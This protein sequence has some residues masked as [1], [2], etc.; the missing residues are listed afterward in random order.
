MRKTTLKLFAIFPL[1]LLISCN[2]SSA[3]NVKDK[4]E[5]LNASITADFDSMTKEDWDASINS[6][7]NY[8]KEFEEHK[9]EMSN[10]ERTVINRCIGKFE[11]LC[12]KRYADD[13]TD[14]L[15]DLGE[16]AESFV[17]EIFD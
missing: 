12:A 6:F 3:L 1:F 10:D 8:K 4:M 7:E 16:Q 5:K 14:G 13:F 17:I 9:A 15:K 11:G 2:E